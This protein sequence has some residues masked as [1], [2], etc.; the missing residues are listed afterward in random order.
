M[1]KV[2]QMLCENIDFRGQLSTFRA[3]NTPRSR[4]FEAQYSTLTVTKQPHNNFVKVQNVTFQS[5][6]QR[7]YWCQLIKKGEIL[8]VFL[9]YELYF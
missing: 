1:L 6:K 3:E 7:K 5:P 9:I 4:S 2:G 8:C